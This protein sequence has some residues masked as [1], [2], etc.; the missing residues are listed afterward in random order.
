[1]RASMRVLED[2]WVLLSDMWLTLTDQFMVTDTTDS[3]WKINFNSDLTL[4]KS[5]WSCNLYQTIFSSGSTLHKLKIAGICL[6]VLAPVCLVVAYCLK[7]KSR[8]DEAEP[9]TSQGTDNVGHAAEDTK[10]QTT[11]V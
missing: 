10:D 3:Y 2:S 11:S 1:M 4:T 8:Q 7:H 6:S 9:R 5:P